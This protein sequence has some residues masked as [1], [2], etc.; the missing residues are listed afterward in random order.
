MSAKALPRRKGSPK[1]SISFSNTT[2]N[3]E[4]HRR[5]YRL[6]NRKES[7]VKLVNTAS[8]DQNE[9]E[10]KKETPAVRWESSAS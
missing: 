2:L 5:I 6:L 3:I 7:L 10:K 8:R 1:I 9:A 4:D